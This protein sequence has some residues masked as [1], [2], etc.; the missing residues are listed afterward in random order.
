[1]DGLLVFTYHH[2]R[3]EGWSSILEAL[4]TAGFTITAVHPIKAEMSVAMPKQQAKEP[5][6]LDIIVVCRKSEASAQIPPGHSWSATVMAASAQVQRLRAA[7]RA[8]SRNDIR[9]IVM[10]QALRHFSAL[11][12]AAAALAGLDERLG[13][14]EA[15]IHHLQSGRDG[16]NT[17]AEG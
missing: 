11:S 6:D 3:P 2:S 5:I 1:N 16:I 8:L 17:V 7:R 4:M 13:D 10:A 12:D 9:V 14:I 15:L